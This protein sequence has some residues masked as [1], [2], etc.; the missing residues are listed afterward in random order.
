MLDSIE[1]VCRFA[2]KHLKINFSRPEILVNISRMLLFV[3]RLL[4]LSLSLFRIHAR[5]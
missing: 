3:K 4:H 1:P 5:P 2:S